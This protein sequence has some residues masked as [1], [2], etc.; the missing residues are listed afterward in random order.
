MNP[1][2]RWPLASFVALVLALELLAVLARPHPD[3]MP[4]VLVLVPAVAAATV[5]VLGEGWP[6]LRRLLARI[7]R[8][9]VGLRW[10]AL[11][12]GIPLVGTLLI[13]FAG[14]VLGQADIGELVAAVT[15]AAMAVPLV[16]LLPALLEEMGWRGFGVQSAVERGWSPAAAAL[17]VGLV[18]VAIHLPLYLPGQLYDDLPMWPVP[19]MLL[20]YAAFLSWIYLG[21]GGSVLLAAIGHAVAN[22]ATPLTWGLDPVWVWMARG[23]VFGLIGVVFYLVLAMGGRRAL[24]D[25]RRPGPGDVHEPAAT[26]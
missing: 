4:F 19:L 26:G 7:G 13:D 9:R 3:V 11:A 20:G 8:W 21:S 16:V 1:A 18:F 14:L 6:G 23:I 22:G 17:V 10:Y 2:A 24:G 25:L 12:I 5:A 15:P